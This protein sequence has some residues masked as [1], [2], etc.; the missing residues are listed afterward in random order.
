MLTITNKNLAIKQREP[1]IEN[2]FPEG[3]KRSHR[4]NKPIVFISSRVHPGEI[5]ASHVLNGFLKLL[6]NETDP[7][8]IL[9]R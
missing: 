2:I 5:V 9:L 3:G 4:F 6:L 8:A 1:K 7:Q